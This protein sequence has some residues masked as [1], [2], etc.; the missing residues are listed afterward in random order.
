VTSGYPATN[1]PE[2]FSA[3]IRR[4]ADRWGPMPRGPDIHYD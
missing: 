3:F 4:E 1:T 2:E